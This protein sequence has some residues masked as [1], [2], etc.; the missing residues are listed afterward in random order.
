MSSP[1]NFQ[2][3]VREISRVKFYLHQDLCYS[4][5]ED[6]RQILEKILRTSGATM[7]VINLS[8]S[9][10]NLSLLQNEEIQKMGNKIHEFKPN[11]KARR[12]IYILSLTM[13]LFYLLVILDVNYF[14]TG[15]VS[16]LGFVLHI[17]ALILLVVFMCMN[18]KF[19]KTIVMKAHIHDDQKLKVFRTHLEAELPQVN[20]R[21]E[22]FNLEFIINQNA[23]IIELIAT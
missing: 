1:K 21:L 16:I 19:R 17:L 22:E 11:T 10:I 12:W 23:S 13:C 14:Q 2:P 4:L 20:S 5:D 8:L 6:S 18:G 3:E 7:Q 15:S 9:K